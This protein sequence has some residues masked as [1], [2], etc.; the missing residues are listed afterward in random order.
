MVVKVALPSLD[1]DIHVLAVI[2][3]VW[4]FLQHLFQGSKS[5]VGEALV[6]S[7]YSLKRSAG[8]RLLMLRLHRPFFISSFNLVS[9]ISNWDCQV[10]YHQLSCIRHRR[11]LFFLVGYAIGRLFRRVGAPL[12]SFGFVSPGWRS[13][14][15]FDL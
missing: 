7:R 5:E 3:I 13:L 14:F 10:S 8:G 2:I 15:P 1:N 11:V 6:N 4:R 9:L 12:V